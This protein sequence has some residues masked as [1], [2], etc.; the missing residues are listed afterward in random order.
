MNKPSKH[1]ASVAPKVRFVTVDEES[2]GQRLDN[3]LRVQLKGVPKTLLYRV[4]RKGE[5]RVNKGRVKAEYKLIAGDQIRIPPVR[6]RD[7]KGPVPVGQKLT[8]QLAAAIIYEDDRLLVINKPFGLAVHGGSGISLGLIEALRQLRPESRF[9]ELVHRLDRD[10]SGLVMVAKKRSML[11]HLHQELQAKRIDKIYRTLVIGRW[12]NRKELV[13][14]PLYKFSLP[15]GERMVRVTPDGKPSKTRYKVLERF[16][17]A[18]LLEAAPVSGRT[19]QIRVHCQH[20]GH[21]I[22]GDPKYCPEDDN[23][24]MAGYGLRRLFLHAYQLRF[25]HP[26]R[27]AMELIAPLPDE[28]LAGLEQLRQP[29]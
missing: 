14:A 11:R 24:A 1:S 2:A 27:G 18:T 19:H 16:A 7:E 20:A 22:A 13:N 23:A 28:L 9:L 3:F 12:P 15:S 4:I 26:E 8:E 17:Q 10:T 25:M 21:P 29:S 5:V 6:T